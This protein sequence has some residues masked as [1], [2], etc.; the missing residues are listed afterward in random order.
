MRLPCRPAE[1]V[2]VH[3]GRAGIRKEKPISYGCGAMEKNLLEP[4]EEL[5]DE[6][7]ANAM[8]GWSMAAAGDRKRPGSDSP[9]G[10]RPPLSK[11]IC[12][13]CYRTRVPSPWVRRMQDARP[14]RVDSIP[15]RTAVDA[16]DRQKIVIAPNGLNVPNA[17]NPHD[18]LGVPEAPG[19]F[20][21]I[22]SIIPRQY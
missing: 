10:P 19:G 11:W 9:G 16:F 14:A 6:N 4:A 12:R 22:C 1:E 15:P 8:P 3:I 17:Q 20:L 5:S 18:P 21:R 7:M 2:R 13:K